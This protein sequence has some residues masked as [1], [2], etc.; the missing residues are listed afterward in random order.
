MPAPERERTVRRVPTIDGLTAPA[1][2]ALDLATG[3]GLDR[4]VEATKDARVVLLGEA[5]HGDGATF[6]AKAAIIRHLHEHAGFDLLAW[7]AGLYDCRRMDDAFAAG[8]DPMQ[9]L[10]LG[11]HAIWVTEE[12]RPLA[13]HI[14]ASWMTDRPLRQVGFDPQFS[15]VTSVDTVGGD[16]ARWLAEEGIAV[17]ADDV[18]AITAL[19]AHSIPF[20]EQLDEAARSKA[21]AAISHLLDDARD[22]APTSFVTR[23]LDDVLQNDDIYTPL[24]A[25]MRERKAAIGGDFA[26]WANESDELYK[27]HFSKR[28]LLMGRNLLH[29]VETHPESRVV[30][31]LANGHAQRNMSRVGNGDPR[32]DTLLTMGSVVCESLG[33]DA[34]VVVATSHSG[35]MNAG[36]HRPGQPIP[37]AAPGS[38]EDVLHDTAGPMA[39]IDARSL[40]ADSPWRQPS[41]WRS[42]GPEQNLA[43]LPEVADGVLYID[44]QRPWHDLADS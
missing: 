18:A 22:R 41:M 39:F 30:C 12:L 25:W 2:T 26:Q 21:R 13:E 24:N 11:A 44:V 32:F 9:A 43:P 7:E 23:V 17:G 27:Q 15:S 38:L 37:P 14:S 1:T 6:A 4:L 33:D 8:V 5:T 19:A 28:D 40:P 42:W 3:A 10:A 31:W 36:R 16:V 29:E 34:Y 35:E 20:R